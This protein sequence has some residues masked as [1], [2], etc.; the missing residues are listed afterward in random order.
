MSGLARFEPLLE[1]AIRSLE[2]G[3][4]QAERLRA[5][6]KLARS[7]STDRIL[8]HLSDESDSCVQ[9]AL[10]HAF[11]EAYARTM[12]EFEMRLCSKTSAMGA[13]GTVGERDS[14][15]L[16]ARIQAQALL[17]NDAARSAPAIAALERIAYGHL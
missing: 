4:P 8:R 17:Q 15:A 2:P 1:V 16:K 5:A 12:K 10:S 13:I 7:A 9:D 11:A 3:L 14:Y 6:A